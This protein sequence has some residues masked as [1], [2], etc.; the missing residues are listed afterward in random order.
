MFCYKC[1]NRSREYPPIV[2]CHTE[3][4]KVCRGYFVFR[5]SSPLQNPHFSKQSKGWGP[6]GTVSSPLGISGTLKKAGGPAFLQLYSC[7]LSATQEQLLV[8]VVP[9]SWEGHGFA[10]TC[11][12]GPGGA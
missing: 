8:S 3:W 11:S 6:A 1:L 10:L 4:R 2:P 12:A 7:P 9:R 5:V